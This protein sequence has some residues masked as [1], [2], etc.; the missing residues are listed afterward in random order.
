MDKIP[1]PDL[2]KMD[3]FDTVEFEGQTVIGKRFSEPLNILIIE[4]K[5]LLLHLKKKNFEATASH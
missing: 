3:F 1:I 5:K 2:T 4:S